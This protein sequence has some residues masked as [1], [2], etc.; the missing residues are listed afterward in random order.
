M[1]GIKKQ[2]QKERRLLYHTTHKLL[3]PQCEGKPL[4][5]L[6]LDHMGDIP[7]LVK[8]KCATCGYDGMFA[9][10]PVSK[11]CYEGKTVEKSET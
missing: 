8:S 5:K 4:T 10:V 6:M 11:M 9:E 2:T 1:K 7:L 3:C